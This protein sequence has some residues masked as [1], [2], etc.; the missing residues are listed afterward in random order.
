MDRIFIPTVNRVS[1]EF[2]FSN[3]SV[4]K[5]KTMKSDIWSRLTN[6]DIDKD[7]RYIAGKLPGLFEVV[8]DRD[9]TRAAGGFRDVGKTKTWWSKAYKNGAREVKKGTTQRQ[10]S[11]NAAVL[12]PGD[13][14]VVLSSEL[15]KQIKRHFKKDRDNRFELFLLSHAIREKYLDKKANDYTEEFRDFYEQQDLESIYGKLANFTKYASAGSVIEYVK[16]STSD[17]D[18]YLNQLPVGVNALYEIS[19]IIKLDETALKA[20]WHFTPRRKSKTAKKHEWITS[21]TDPLIRPDVTFTELSA[22]R[23]RWE[24]PEQEEAEQDKYQRN[25]KLLT[26]SV[27]EDIFKFDAVGNKKGVVDLEEVV[28]LL[29]RVQALLNKGNEKQFRLDSQIERIQERYAAAKEKND[30]TNVLKGKK[31]GSSYKND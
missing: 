30:P 4:M 13:N 26:L 19:L 1:K 10:A 9:G 11:G 7:H 22:W 17:P 21:G 3:R 31:K 14:M 5:Q 24:E 2:V 16:S 6:K 12:T 27:S 25:V 28:S 23:K 20:C 15:A 8:Y 29:E 18:K